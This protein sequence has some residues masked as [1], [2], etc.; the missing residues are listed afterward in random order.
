MPA[1]RIEFY[2]QLTP[3][4]DP[5]GERRLV[6]VEIRD[7]KSRLTEI[8]ILEAPAPHCN[9]CGRLIET[10]EDCFGFDGGLRCCSCPP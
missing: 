7:T 1:T 10:D 4:T 6:L 8:H 9:G 2:V 5:V 3:V